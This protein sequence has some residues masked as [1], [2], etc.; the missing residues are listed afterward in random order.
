MIFFILIIGTILLMVYLTKN[1]LDNDIKKEID[2]HAENDTTYEEY[3]YYGPN[4]YTSWELG[5]EVAKKNNDWSKLPL[6]EK[7]RKK[8]NE[9]DGILGDLQFDNI[10]LTPYDND[11]KY[12]NKYYFV[13][14]NNYFVIT[15]GKQKIAYVYNLKYDNELLSDVW[16]RD[17]CNLTNEDGEELI[18]IGYEINK[19]NFYDSM[20]NLA[21]GGNDERSV[22][23]TEKFHKKYPYFLDIFIHYSPIG[24]N[25]II[26]EE[27]DYDKRIAYFTVDSILEC[28]KREYEVKF[29]LDEKGYLDDVSVKILNEEPYER[30]ELVKAY[31]AVFYKNSNWNCLKLTDKFRKKFKK[32]KGVFKDIDLIDYNIELQSIIYD[33]NFIKQY[34]YK[35]GSKK[36]FYKKFIYVEDDY[37]DDVEIIPISYTGS[38]AEEAKEVYIK[39]QQ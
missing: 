35:S 4:S 5:Y 16:I 7:F 26:F 37:L 21:R 22:A 36:W 31:D 25:E 11:E 39:S 23:V 3:I 20:Y 32:E 13:N 34:Q 27:G 29:E 2:F 19:K 8:Y 15:I 17:I 24:A 18:V 12:S 33:N 30:D 6:S 1:K 38:D 9:K 10:E 28:I 14:R